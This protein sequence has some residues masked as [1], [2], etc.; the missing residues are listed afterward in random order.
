MLL[1]V[2]LDVVTVGMALPN[3]ELAVF[4]HNRKMM[5]SGHFKRYCPKR[6]VM[7]IN[8]NDEYETGDDAGPD[9]PEDD[10]YDSDGVD[11][12]PSEARTI[13]VSQRALNM[14]PSASTQRCNLFQ[15]KALVGPDK[16]CKV[17]IDG[18]S[19]RNLASKELCPKLKLKDLPHPH[20]YYIQWLSDNGEM[21]ESHVGDLMG[22]FGREKMLLMLADHLYWPKMRRD[23]DK[24]EEGASI[25]R[26]GEEQLDMVLDMKTFDGRAREEW[27][28]CAGRK[29][30][31][32]P[33]HRPVRPGATPACPTPRPVQ[34]DPTPGEPGARR[35]LRGCQPGGC[36]ERPSPGPVIARSLARSKLDRPVPGPVDRTPDVGITLR[37]T[38]VTLPLAAQPGAHEGTRWPGGPLR[39]FPR[40]HPDPTRLSLGKISLDVVFGTPSNFRKEK[41]EFEVVDWESQYH[42]ILGRPAFAKFMA[43]P[44]YAYLKLKMPGNNMTAIT[45]HGSFSRSDNCDRDFQKIASKFGAKEELNALDVVTDHTQP[46]GDNQNIKSDE[47]DIAKESK[48]QQVHPSDSKKTVNTSVDLA[49]S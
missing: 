3:S 21:K 36:T 49:V 6:K 25:A 17:I 1:V 11:A 44:H 37:V 33:A 35:I 22:H 9:A 24:Y 32:R 40:H 18:G 19:C 27:E 29:S 30:K 26:G 5:V 38:N 34:S 45:V 7:I 47:F 10:D 43:V 31:Y 14:Q 39:R 48:K 16:A 23:V 41:L 2:E 12:F 28:A 13:V 42:A 20:P 15:T 4:S 8:D 46:P